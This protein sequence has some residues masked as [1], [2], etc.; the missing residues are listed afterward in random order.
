MAKTTPYTMTIVKPPVK[1]KE[2]SFPQY[3]DTECITGNIKHETKQS[4]FKRRLK[5][6]NW[7]HT[8]IS[9]SK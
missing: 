1:N 2:I 6:E 9:S 4:S 3:V 8:I 7:R 5:K